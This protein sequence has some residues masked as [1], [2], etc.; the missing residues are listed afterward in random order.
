MVLAYRL[1]KEGE[2]LTLEKGVGVLG[3]DDFKDH[4]CGTLADKFEGEVI[5]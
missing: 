5:A 3:L 2:G 4:V 1:G